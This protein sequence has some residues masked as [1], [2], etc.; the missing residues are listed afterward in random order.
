MGASKVKPSADMLRQ[1]QDWLE[2]GLTQAQ[3]AARLGVSQGTIS[4]HVR[5]NFDRV[6]RLKPKSE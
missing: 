5:E 3:M 1:L 6:L 2:E 4:R